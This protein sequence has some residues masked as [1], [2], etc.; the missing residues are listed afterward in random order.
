MAP[1]LVKA[2]RPGEKGPQH[3]NLELR[4]RRLER[5]QNLLKKW[6]LELQRVLN[7]LDVEKMSRQE[8]PNSTCSLM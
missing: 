3:D 1:T 5:T 2:G 4:L 7:R 8:A 6:T